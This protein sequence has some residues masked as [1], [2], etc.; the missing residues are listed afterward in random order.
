L[1]G[2]I[3]AGNSFGCANAAAANS[4]ELEPGFENWIMSILNCTD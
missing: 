4:I 2:D 1:D 3:P